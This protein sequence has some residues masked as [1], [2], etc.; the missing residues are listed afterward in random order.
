[1]SEMKVGELVTVLGSSTLWTVVGPGG[2]DKNG[3]LVTLSRRH[4]TRTIY[5]PEY[6]KKLR[7]PPTTQ[8][9]TA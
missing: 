3:E 8:G 4:G 5:R 2:H 6:V 7:K 1:M 9:G